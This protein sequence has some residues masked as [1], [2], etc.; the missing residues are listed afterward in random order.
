MSA[1]TLKY[2]GVAIMWSK[3]IFILV[4]LL[5]ISALIIWWVF[6]VSFDTFYLQMILFFFALFIGILAAFMGVR[7]KLQVR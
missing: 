5:T 7:V 6:G 1:E 3:M 2:S 4:F